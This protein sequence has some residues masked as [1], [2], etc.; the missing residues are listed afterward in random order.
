MYLREEKIQQMYN[1][2]RVVA[3]NV[4]R[5]VLPQNPIWNGNIREMFGDQ[6]W[7]NL[8]P[9]LEIAKRE[10]VSNTELLSAI[11][12]ALNNN[13]IETIYFNPIAKDQNGFTLMGVWLVVPKKS[14]PQQGQ[15]V[16][17]Q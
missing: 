4:S 3:E 1:F 15:Q 6:Y 8:Y 12:L 10:D 7:I 9:F 17:Q 5:G 14:Q 13:I 16:Q 2:I 11:F